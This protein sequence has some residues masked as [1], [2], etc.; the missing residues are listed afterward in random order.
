M[1]IK[2]KI[3]LVALSVLIL[4]ALVVT[5]CMGTA[6][7]SGWAGGAVSDGKLFVASM[8]GK[9]IA[10]EAS[11]GTIL[12][13][14]VQ[15]AM[16][17][18]GGLSCLPS[19]CGGQSSSSVVIYASPAVRGQI[20][21]VGGSDGKIS[22]YSFADNALREDPEWLYP[23]QGTMSGA[24]IGGIIV[25]NDRVYFATSNGTVYALNADGLYKEWTY[26]I[27]GKVWSAPIID[28]NTL[29][30]GGLNKKVYA[31]NG[32]DGTKMWEYETAGAI[33]STPVVYD[34]KVYI[35]DY[36]RQFYALDA[37]TGNLVWEFPT[38][39]KDETSPQNWFW[40]K[41]LVLNGIVY[42]P[43]LDGNVYAL[44]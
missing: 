5:G 3:I 22:G 39:G 44:N 27:G 8:T 10:I 33:S 1:S 42:A 31:L 13:D 11:T 23:R 14:P 26:N 38:T 25:A 4:G 2:H 16:P 34:G 43:C 41:P 30:I 9:I 40:A 19:S 32:T 36:D 18:S 15:L 17:A 24:I 35:G 7:S 28:G 29:Y 20:V 21:Y 12:G 37:V 6:V